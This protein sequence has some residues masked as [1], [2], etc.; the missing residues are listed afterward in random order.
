MRPRRKR[1]RNGLLRVRWKPSAP[2]R[3]ARLI[4]PWRTRISPSGSPRLLLLEQRAQ[5]LLLGHRGGAEQDVAQARAQ[6]QNHVFGLRLVQARLQGQHRV[7]LGLVDQAELD[8]QRA[9]LAVVLDLALERGVERARARAGPPGRG[10]RRGGSRRLALDSF[11]QSAAMMGAA[12]GAVEEL[13]R[14][15]RRSSVKLCLQGEGA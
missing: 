9:E 14:T 8:Q 1:S 7:E 4:A 15:R 3:T 6:E 5:Q 11:C 2:S 10:A 13:C 12:R